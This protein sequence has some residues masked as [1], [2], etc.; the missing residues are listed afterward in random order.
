MN[1][2]FEICGANPL[3]TQTAQCPVCGESG[4]KVRIETLQNIIKDNL[5]PTTLEGYC[6]CLSNKCA[7]IYFG[8]QV[9]YKDDIKVKVWFKEKD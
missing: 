9:F 3:D 7:V 6:L 4:K 1:S 2:V 8:Q 5:V